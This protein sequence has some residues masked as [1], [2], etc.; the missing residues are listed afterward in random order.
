MVL[1]LKEKKGFAVNF[2]PGSKL[3]LVFYLIAAVI[4]SCLFMMITLITSGFSFTLSGEFP[5]GDL[6]NDKSINASDALHVIMRENKNMDFNGAQIDAGDVNGD[7][8]IN[9]L[10]ATLIIQY[11][12]ET[13][14]KLG[15]LAVGNTKL[16][17]PAGKKT[18]T[19]D[20]Q[21]TAESPEESFVRSG[22]SYSAAFCTSESD[23]YTSA[24]IVNKWYT[25][26]K[27]MYQIEIAMKNNSGQYI[28][29]SS[30]EL[31]FSSGVTLEKNWKCYV[32]SDD[33]RLNITTQ[34]YQYV[35]DGGVMKCGLIV[36]STTD[37]ELESVSK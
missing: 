2:E 8:V 31:E 17:K 35:P 22:N 12:S 14:E 23:V 19:A 30:L 7:G 13:S 28:G 10:D 6:N 36:S 25:D 24:R 20:S 4:L 18:V 26:N 9:E 3:P 34:C 15:V 21:Q 37:I 11:A 29:D 16:E 32:E 33:F 27:Y 1:L 5:S